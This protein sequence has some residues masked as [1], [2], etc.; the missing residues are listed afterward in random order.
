MHI[1]SESPAQQ[2]THE[3]LILIT[4]QALN[5]RI[6]STSKTLKISTTTKH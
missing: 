5:H 6:I 2:T 3:A 4:R 1:I